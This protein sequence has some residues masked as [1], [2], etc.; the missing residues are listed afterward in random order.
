LRVTLLVALSW[1]LGFGM[2]WAYA[3]AAPI[4]PHTQQSLVSAGSGAHCLFHHASGGTP[5]PQ[6][7]SSRIHDC[8]ALGGCVCHCTHSPL[9]SDLPQV[10]AAEVCSC[11]L[12]A[13][14]ARVPIARL[15][16]FFKPPIA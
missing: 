9:A 8:C 11:L 13:I 16:E 14:E 15:D 1:Q 5:L 12:P 3:H 10:S 6:H 4:G 2:Q 7:D